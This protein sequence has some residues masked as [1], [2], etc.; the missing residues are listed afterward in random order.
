VFSSAVI[1]GV[2]FASLVYLKSRQA[3]VNELR[4]MQAMDLG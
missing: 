4:R 2:A 1:A 3:Q